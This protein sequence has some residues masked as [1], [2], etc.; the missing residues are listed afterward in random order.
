[1]KTGTLILLRHG[2]TEYNRQDLLTGLADPMLTEKGRQQA[3]RAGSEIQGMH[4]HKVFSSQLRRSFTTAALML[5]AAQDKDYLRDATG[6]FQIERRKELNERDVGDFTG[7]PFKKDPEI[8]AYYEKVDRGL[9]IAPPGGESVDDVVRRLRYF[10]R[11]DIRSRLRQG[12][13]VLIVAHAGILRGFDNMF[14]QGL[15][16]KQRKQSPIK[17]VENAKPRFIPY[18]TCAHV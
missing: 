12:E 16:Y 6:A 13:N 10:Y 14:A 1:M 9:D 3:R 4:I 11:S 5:H 15:R 7:R 2:Q 18:H 8:M 17:R